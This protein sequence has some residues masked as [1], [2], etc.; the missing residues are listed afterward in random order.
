MANDIKQE[1]KT[2]QNHWLKLPIDFCQSKSMKKLLRSES[3]Q[4]IAIF[5]LQI[6]LLTVGTDGNYLFE[7]VEDTI[8]DEI[9][10]ELD[11][12]ADTI[13]SYLEVLENLSLIKRKK[14]LI[15]I[16][17][18]TDHVGKKDISSERVA[19]YRQR[20]K[21]SCNADVTLHETECNADETE[22]NAPRVREEKR[23]EELDL[24]KELDRNHV[25]FSGLDDKTIDALLDWFK[26]QQEHFNLKIDGGYLKSL[27]P[28]IEANIEAG[29]DIEYSVN[30]IMSSRNADG[31]RTKTLRYFVNPN[32]EAKNKNLSP[33]ERKKQKDA[34]LKKEDRHNILSNYCKGVTYEEAYLTLNK[35]RKG[36]IEH[37]PLRPAEVITKSECDKYMIK[38]PTRGDWEML[39]TE[40]EGF[41][42]TNGNFLEGDCK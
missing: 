14:D 40:R 7:G 20:S 28:I 21:E 18:V 42:L 4:H 2:K 25:F 31:S 9:S 15:S 41:L 11:F 37:Y 26:Y 23:R 6:S 32:A 5:Y 22:S 34:Q 8:E 38:Y 13:K 16:P 10:L 33:E 35:K 12:S 19:R 17:F 24:K 1:T 36:E 39:N 27:K 3:N 29:N 30:F